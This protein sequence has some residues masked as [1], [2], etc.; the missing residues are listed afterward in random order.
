MPEGNNGNSATSPT[1]IP[2]VGVYVCHC[3]TNIASV[4][5]VNA[6]TEYAAGLPGV[7]VSREYKYMCSD[8]GQE[9][10]RQDIREHGLESDCGGILL[11]ADA[12][13]NV[14]R[15]ADAG[16]HQS[17]SAADGQHPRARILGAHEQAGRHYKRRRTWSARRYGAC[18]GTSLWRRDELRS[19]PVCWWSAEALPAF[20]PP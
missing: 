16:G 10:I 13:A 8:P 6:L 12:R 18:I 9:L 15:S 17:V 1:P 4:V 2:K 5:D 3:G 11:T 14:S 20:M 7:V 19:I